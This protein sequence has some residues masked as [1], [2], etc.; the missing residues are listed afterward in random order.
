M[1]AYRSLDDS[2]LSDDLTRLG[3][4]EVV[5][6]RDTNGFAG[7]IAD[8]AITATPVEDSMF[9]ARG[10]AEYLTRHFK[11][12]SLRG[13]GLEDDDPRVSADELHAETVGITL[14][15]L[16]RG[17]VGD[18]VGIVAQRFVVAEDNVLRR[19]VASARLRTAPRLVGGELGS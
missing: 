14:A 15:A 1:T 9:E 3:A 10:A 6:P 12:Q 18:V 11:T 8:R 5:I 7:R 2:R 16:D 19:A 13:F 17:V 4:R